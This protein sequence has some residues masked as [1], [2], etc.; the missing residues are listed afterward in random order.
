MRTGEPLGQAHEIGP[1]GLAIAL[2]CKPFAAAAET[3]HDLVGDEQNA[4]TAG[5]PTQQGP[6]VVR[7]DDPV[8]SGIGFHQHRGDASGPVFVDHVTDVAAAP[9]A[10]VRCGR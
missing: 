3:A 10:A 1:A 5:F 8:G 6:V 4:A 9:L 7:C 2:P